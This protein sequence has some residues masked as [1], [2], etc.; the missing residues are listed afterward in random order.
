[1]HQTKPPKPSPIGETSLYYILDTICN[2]A[3]TGRGRK[4]CNGRFAGKSS[5]APVVGSFAY[6]PKC[7][8]QLGKIMS[9]LF[10]YARKHGENV[11]CR[12]FLD[13]GCGIGMSMHLARAAGFYYTDGLE[14]DKTCIT[15]ARQIFG[16][17]FTKKIKH[18]NILT[19][20]GYGLYDAIYF[21]VPFS[22][23][24]KQLK[25]EERIADQMKV[26]AIVAP[27]SCGAVFDKDPRFKKLNG[28]IKGKSGFSWHPECYYYVK[29]RN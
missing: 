16:A 9:Q 14:L 26:G 3:Q 7:A 5:R 2:E 11:P 19:F 12:R 13:A 1:M 23:H 28:R 4:K 8:D 15:R 18:Q 29:R 6:V 22:D 27:A 20:N 24:L 21:W 10:F 25:M 17:E